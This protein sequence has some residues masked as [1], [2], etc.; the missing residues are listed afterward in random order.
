MT[1]LS[2]NGMAFWRRMTVLKHRLAQEPG[3]YLAAFPLVN[4]GPR[5]VM[6]FLHLRQQILKQE[7]QASIDLIDEV[8]LHPA[9][10]HLMAIDGEDGAII[11]YARITTADNVWKI[12]WLAVLQNY[13][14][15]GIGA[16]ILTRATEIVSRAMCSED[17]IVIRVQNKHYKWYEQLGFIPTSVPNI[18]DDVMCINM[19]YQPSE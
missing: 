11:G 2:K 1:I 5:E 16:S 19:R 17:A 15:R 6:E 9:S 8:D 12:S 10:F 18:F 7:G 3:H 14:N 4:C 13:R